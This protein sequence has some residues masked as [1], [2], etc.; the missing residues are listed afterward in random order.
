M[1]TENT[2]VVIQHHKNT[3][4]I[5]TL[6]V[7][8]AVDAAI[9]ALAARLKVRSRDKESKGQ[10]SKNASEHDEGQRAVDR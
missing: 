8:A 9:V 4:R 3:T 6:N 5:Y 2:S 1:A 10:K 7:I